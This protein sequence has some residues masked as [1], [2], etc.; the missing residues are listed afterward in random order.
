[1]EL[2]DP[3]IN[4]GKIIAGR[5]KG[6]PIFEKDPK[7]EPKRKPKS[8]SKRKPKKMPPCWI[9]CPDFI[10]QPPK[11][12]DLEAGRES[13]YYT[14]QIFSETRKDRDEMLVHMINC[15]Q[16]EIEAGDKRI[17]LHAVNYST[18]RA[19]LFLAELKYIFRVKQAPEEIL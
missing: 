15:G 9:L 2:F 19:A 18:G 16:E 4:I 7:K 10:V 3:E 12:V 11:V 8:K 5:V 6:Y 17:W 14:I 1:M 13:Y